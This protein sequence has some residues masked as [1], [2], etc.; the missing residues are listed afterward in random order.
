MPAL[1]LEGRCRDTDTLLIKAVKS[2]QHMEC[3]VSLIDKGLVGINMIMNQGVVNVNNLHTH[4][5]EVYTENGVLVAVLITVL[6]ERRGKKD[7]SLD[8][9]IDGAEVLVGVFASVLQGTLTSSGKFVAVTE[10]IVLAQSF[11]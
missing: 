2:R 10:L 4:L 8:Q 1:Q 5:L 9:E 11:L 7:A 6:W 3:L